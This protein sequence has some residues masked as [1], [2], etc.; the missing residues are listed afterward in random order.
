VEGIRYRFLLATA[1]ECIETRGPMTRILL[2]LV[3]LQVVATPLQDR[4]GAVIGR[5][6]V[7]DGT[8]VAAIRVAVRRVADVTNGDKVLESISLTDA[9]GR[10]RLDNIAPGRYLVVVV[11]NGAEIYSPGVADAARAAVVEVRA[12]STVE[13]PD[14]VFIQTGVSGRVVDAETGAG[15]RIEQLSICCRFTP[16]VAGYL[17]SRYGSP[18]ATTSPITTTVRDD[19]TFVFADVPPGNHYFYAAD[20]EMIAVGLPL[21]VGNEVIRSVEVKVS[22]GVSVR[23]SIVDHL[24]TPVAALSLRLRAQNLNNI[25]DV[26]GTS[27]AAGGTTI[28]G[29]PGGAVSPP[30][31]QDVLARLAGLTLPDSDGTFAFD[32]VMPGA[33]VLETNA[34]G[35]DAFKQ[36]IVVGTQGVSGIRVQ[37]PSTLLTG[38]VLTQ[39]GKE[40]PS[41]KGALLLSPS[42]GNPVYAFPDDEGR[43]AVLLTPGEYRLSADAL[44][45]PVHS[46]FDGTTDL[47][48]SPLRFDGLTRKEIRINLN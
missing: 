16:A 9:T 40:L 37:L 33:Y 11:R 22:K 26:S 44:G 18:R 21:L 8:P 25:F 24:G 12:S 39:G 32:R 48:T 38:R 35:P 15:R 2:A 29:P 31:A 3:F 47:M 4:T 20:P 10:Y 45:P 43:F 41:L 1:G 23:G 36:E 28:V 19:G 34:T 30:S 7:D 27:A 42:T 6:R 5:V 13:A 46:V 17:A 14:V